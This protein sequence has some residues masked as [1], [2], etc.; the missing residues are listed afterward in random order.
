M[1]Y[2]NRPARVLRT[3]LVASVLVGVAL[4]APLPNT[5]PAAEA[6][7]PS[8]SNFGNGYATDY[9]WRAGYGQSAVV[10]HRFNT[11]CINLPHYPNVQTRVTSRHKYTEG[12]SGTC[13]VPYGASGCTAS[14]LMYGGIAQVGQCKSK[15]ERVWGVAWLGFEPVADADYNTTS[16]VCA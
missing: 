15:T 9:K 5:Q 13:V 6:A 12:I 8:C 11:K 7:S 3:L 4:L 10:Y 2:A 14:W 16:R 1:N